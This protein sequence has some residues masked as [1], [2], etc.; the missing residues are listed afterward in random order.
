MTL[1]L[2]YYACDFP[3]PHTPKNS[4]QHILLSA[5]PENRIHIRAKVE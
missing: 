4:T 1:I 3:S 5:L 2:V